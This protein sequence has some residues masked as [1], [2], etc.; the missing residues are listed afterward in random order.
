MK[1]MTLVYKNKT[2]LEERNTSP[3]SV[4]EN[5][6]ILLITPQYLAVHSSEGRHLL[7]ATMFFYGLCVY[8]VIC[9]GACPPHH[10]KV[11]NHLLIAT[12]NIKAYSPDFNFPILYPKLF[13]SVVL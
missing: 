7:M 13:T 2:K 3:I 10:C 8:L 11:R 6:K 12:F 9:L 5:Q 1:R 4:S